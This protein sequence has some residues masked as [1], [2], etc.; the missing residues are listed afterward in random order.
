MGIYGRFTGV[1]WKKEI[2]GHIGPPITTF[3]GRPIGR[4]VHIN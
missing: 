4:I 2:I 1:L 3:E